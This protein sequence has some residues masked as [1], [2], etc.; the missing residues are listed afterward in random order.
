M[1]PVITYNHHERKH[2]EESQCRTITLKKLFSW[3]SNK[4]YSEISIVVALPA[5]FKSD[6]F[7]FLWIYVYFSILRQVLC[8]PN[9]KLRWHFIELYLLA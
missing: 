3:N 6:S 5:H 1:K 9:R 2:T 8:S 7:V 4:S